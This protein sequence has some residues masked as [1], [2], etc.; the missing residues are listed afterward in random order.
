MG[1]KYYVVWEGRE[2][3]VYDN[4]ED[5]QEQI[6]GFPG[7]KYKSF[8]NKDTAVEAFRGD[9]AQHLNLFKA[10]RS[11]QKDV[12]NYDE[13]PEIIQ[14]AVAVDGAC[15]G[16]PGRMEYQGVFVASGTR[17]FHFG[18]AE[19]GTNN[20]AEFLAL[21]HAMAWLK[22]IQR[23]DIAIYTDSRTA[24]AWVRNK[25]AKTTLQPTPANMKLLQLVERAEAWLHANPDCQNRILKWETDKWGEIPADFGRK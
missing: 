15:A 2:P 11:H 5:C 13:F 22:Q 23:P 16:N 10:W 12:V 18:P 4:W 21:V 14:N 8:P 6:D 24:M 9:I 3:G 19:G 20:I 25:H 7:A 1:K 17:V